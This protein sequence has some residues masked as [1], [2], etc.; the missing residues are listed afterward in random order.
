MQNRKGQGLI[1][2]LILTCL[3]AISAIAVVSTV[4]KSI[5]TQYANISN[6]ITGKGRKIEG[7]EVDKDAY[8]SRGM[9]DFMDSAHKER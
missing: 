9:E 1:E 5:K 7:S 2:Y 6:A 4:G 8:Q 3:I